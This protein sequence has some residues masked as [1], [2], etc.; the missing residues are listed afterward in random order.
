L[1][2][3]IRKIKKNVCIVICVV[4][5]LS[6]LFIFINWINNKEYTID[7]KYSL[8]EVAESNFNVSN[9]EQEN[10]KS[11]LRNRTIEDDHYF[12]FAGNNAKNVDLYNA[13]AA[14][15]FAKILGNYKYDDLKLRLSFLS[16]T[17]VD[18]LD[19]LNLIYDINICK[20][21]S[22]NVDYSIINNSLMKFYDHN[23]N[24]FFVN[25][26]NESIHTKIIATAMCKKAMGE[27]LS[28]K[29]FSSEKGIRNA[30]ND[31]NF[32]TKNNV[33][34]YNSG[35]DIIY[36]YSVFNMIDEIKLDNLK[37]WFEYWK[38]INESI[39]ID[40]FITTLQYSEYLNI[41][42]IFDPGYSSKKL[43]DYYIGITT[44]NIAE[45]NDLYVISNVVKNVEPLDNIKVNKI[46]ENEID[47]ALNNDDLYDFKIDIKSTAFGVILAQKTGFAINKDKI[48]NYIISNYKDVDS[49]SN[50]Y[51]RV[52]ALYYNL[53][54]DQAVNGYNIEYNKELFQSQIDKTLESIDYSSNISVDILSTRRLV[55]LVMDLQIF[56]TDVKISNAQVKKIKN[57]VKKA[58]SDDSIVSTSVICDLFIINETLSLDLISNQQFLDVFNELTCDG[59]NKSML[60]EDLQPDIL[61]T[62]QFMNCLGRLNNYD[63]LNRQKEFVDSMMIKDGIYKLDK[64]S[65]DANDLSAVLYGVNI[66]HLQI[67]G[68]KID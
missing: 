46:L 13:N 21:L 4:L 27:E 56:D 18:S 31:Y 2:K 7:D 33:T 52:A 53:I 14:V 42:T 64:G 1:K 25:N 55:E 57:G 23:L 66:K 49:I 50:N 59:G 62:Y 54:L 36:C 51:E 9:T 63:H 5:I 43:Y 10:I 8:S 58:F 60:I 35:A 30:Y 44:E 38:N 26:A 24:L 20:A 29:L 37:L 61:T 12:G 48:N 41:A 6:V 65:K 3:N 19:F 32:Q 28:K 68:S 47:K 45:V 40:S 67:G 11:M 22:I 16:E 15:E 34:F 17:N 39:V